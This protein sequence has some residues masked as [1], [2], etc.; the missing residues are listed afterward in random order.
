MEYPDCKILFCTY[1]IQKKA[2]EFE[3]EIYDC[4][5]MF[6]IRNGSIAYHIDAGGEQHEL[7]AGQLVICPPN[8]T[9]Y[10][11]MITPSDICMIKL[12]AEIPTELCE[13]PFT[14][15]DLSRYNGNLD[16]LIDCFFCYDFELHTS[17]K[18]YCR[19]IW[20][21]VISQHIISISPLEK[22]L[23][24]IKANFTSNISISDLA[25]KSGYSTGGF[26]ACFKKNYGHTPQKYI[27]LL[28][29][30]YARQLLL[31]TK[32]SIS[33]IAFACGYEDPLY[34][35]KQFKKYTNLSPR[36]FRITD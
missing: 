29:I 20:Y 6:C 32:M 22:A 16:A 23:H 14:V 33:S 26:I 5:T 19:D 7:H 9:F 25:L 35:S 2:F 13:L 3:S 8:K 21:Q 28:R 17:V 4:Y 1:F 31:G 30:N 34:F 12:S 10:R 24:Y 11:E 27:S 36:K 18:H 15:L